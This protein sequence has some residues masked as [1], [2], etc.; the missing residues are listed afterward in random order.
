MFKSILQHSSDTNVAVQKNTSSARAAK[1]KT[2][3]KTKLN[4]AVV[5]EDRAVKVDRGEYN[6]GASYVNK[7]SGGMTQT[8]FIS[9]CVVHCLENDPIVGSSILEGFI[10][11]HL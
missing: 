10:H 9:V 11:S 1:S 4:V 8:L 3:Q 7:E 6:L 5:N 2:D